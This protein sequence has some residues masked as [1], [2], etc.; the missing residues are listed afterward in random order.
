MI[1]LIGTIAIPYLEVSIKKCSVINISS[2]A[3]CGKV[4]SSSSAKANSC[5]GLPKCPSIWHGGEKSGLQIAKRHLSQ[6]PQHLNDGQNDH[7]QN[8]DRQS[9]FHIAANSGNEAHKTP[10]RRLFFHR[11][12]I[13][14]VFFAGLGY[15][16]PRCTYFSIYRLRKK[17]RMFIPRINIV[18]YAVP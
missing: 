11:N 3:S 13:L 10:P 9:R 12:K 17:G 18:K 14:S 1:S 8:D 15:V 2:V 7:D 16:F 5:L 6:I 4:A